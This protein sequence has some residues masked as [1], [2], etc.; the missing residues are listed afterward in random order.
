MVSS[1]RNEAADNRNPRQAYRPSIRQTFFGERQKEE[2]FVVRGNISV[3]SSLLSQKLR[4]RCVDDEIRECMISFLPRLRRFAYALTG[5]ADAGDDLVQDTC[6]RALTRLDQ[7]QAGT[8]LESWMFRIAQNLWR[9]ALRSRRATLMEAPGDDAHEFAGA[10]GRIVVDTR[11]RLRA[12]S[13]GLAELP[14]EQ[15]MVVALVCIDG[16]SY[17]EAADIL[18]VP[19][20]TVMSRLARARRALHVL[21]GD[22]ASGHSPKRE[23]TPN[24]QAN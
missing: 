4:G 7:W 23:E 13:E 8:S 12:V 2:F 11:S 24:G 18:E 22:E 6:V 1:H 21:V 17:K 19:V 20:G 16:R 5:D 10:D 14:S 9:D 15:S 3:V